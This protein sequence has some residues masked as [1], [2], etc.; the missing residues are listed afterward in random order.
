MKDARVARYIF[1]AKSL[2]VVRGIGRCGMRGQ[3]SIA[4]AMT[5]AMN[6]IACARDRGE[7]VNGWC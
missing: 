1:A 7:W 4:R 5:G 3:L 6:V 2:V